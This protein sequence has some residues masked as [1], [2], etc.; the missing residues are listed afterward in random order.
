L[1]WYIVGW[2]SYISAPASSSVPHKARDAALTTWVSVCGPGVM[3]RT[4]TPRQGFDIMGYCN[5]TWASDYTYT[6]I[7]DYLR[8]GVIPIT[9]AVPN[10]VPV[11]LI[12]GSVLGG[13]VDVDPV[14]THRT[15]PT[16]QRAA[17]R[18]VAE[19]IASDGRVLFRHRF[20]GMAVSDADPSALTFLA[21]VPYDATVSGPVARI[22]VRD[23]RGAAREAVRVRAGTYSTLPSGVSLRV[24][25]DPQLIVRNAGGTRVTLTWN[26][27]RYPSLVVR[28][29]RTARVLGIGRRGSMTVDASALGELDV[30]L[31]DGVGSSTRALTISEAP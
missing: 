14:F 29:R 3:M 8:S 20:D 22:T 30:L 10:P 7:L 4:F 1:Q 6:G 31:S 11:L 28:N 15:T 27:A 12:S 25:A 23:Q 26:V 9:A 16:S 21:A 18:F 17:G 13:T 19:G 2:Y 24:D 5:E